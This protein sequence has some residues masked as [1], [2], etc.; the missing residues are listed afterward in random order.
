MTDKRANY[1]SMTTTLPAKAETTITTGSFCISFSDAEIKKFLSD[2]GFA[3]TTTAKTTA[4]PADHN[5]VLITAEIAAGGPPSLSN[6]DS[7]LSRAL[8]HEENRCALVLASCVVVMCAGSVLAGTGQFGALAVW[9]FPMVV[10]Q[11]LLFGYACICWIAGYRV[12]HKFTQFVDD[13]GRAV[14]LQTVAKCHR[15][16]LQFRTTTYHL[17]VQYKVEGLSYLGILHVSKAEHDWTEAGDVVSPL[18]YIPNRPKSIV[19]AYPRR[20]RKRRRL[21]VAGLIC[22]V[23]HFASLA[24]WIIHNGK[25]VKDENETKNVK[26]ASSQE[27]ED[28]LLALFWFV[29]T[30]VMMAF[31]FILIMTK[32]LALSRLKLEDYVT[33]LEATAVTVD[34]RSSLQPGAKAGTRKAADVEEGPE[35][36]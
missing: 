18:R 4:S 32:V 36:I 35:G 25:E 5:P 3:T 22:T 27:V 10:I 13:D 7:G 26:N 28:G 24:L 12:R 23:L 33:V 1:D 8:R 16:F 34:E 6:D 21:V 2:R 9:M 20:E 30:L 17:L 15:E 19:A 14:V 29:L 11:S 31:V